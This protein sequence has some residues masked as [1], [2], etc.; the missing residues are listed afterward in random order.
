MQLL[1]TI[2]AFIVAI[3]YLAGGFKRFSRPKKNCDKCH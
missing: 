3:V 2:L 1:L